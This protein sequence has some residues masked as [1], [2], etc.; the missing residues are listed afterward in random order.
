VG[1]TEQEA[2]GIVRALSLSFYNERFVVPTTKREAADI[3]PYTER[4]FAGFE[5]M[6]PWSPMKRRKSYFKSYHSGSKDYE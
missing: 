2:D 3:S 4:G 5:H 1:L 6:N